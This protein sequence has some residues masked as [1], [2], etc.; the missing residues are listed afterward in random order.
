MKLAIV[1]AQINRYT[2]CVCWLTKIQVLA[3]IPLSVPVAMLNVRVSIYSVNYSSLN[4]HGFT[5]DSF[6]VCVNLMM[7]WEPPRGSFNA[8]FRT[9]SKVR[10]RTEPS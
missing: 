8:C 3:F 2:Y 7:S 10:I 1:V 9:T 6:V 5:Y 4:H